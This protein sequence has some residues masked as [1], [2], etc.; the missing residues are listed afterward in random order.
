MS[1]NVTENTASVENVEN[2]DAPN[3][4]QQAESQETETV[5][6]KARAREWEK[7]SKANADAAKRLA[8]IEDQAK[9]NEQKLA[10]KLAEAEDRAAQAELRVTRRE[11]ALKHNLSQADA[12]LLDGIDDAEVLDKLA[13]RLAQAADQSRKTGAQAPDAGKAPK[14]DADEDGRA[15]IRALTGR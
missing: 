8:E 2:V 6:W 10:E 9:T 14:G 11:V 7:R 13:K 15:F 12:A 1:E 4:E 5:N 3:V